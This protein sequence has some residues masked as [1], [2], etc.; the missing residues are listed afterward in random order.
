MAR[1]LLIDDEANIRLMVRLALEQQKHTVEE[2]ADGDEGL[3]KF[4]DGSGWDLILLDQRMPGIDGLS[5]MKLMRLTSP[6]TKIIMITA[7]GTMDLIMDAITAGA[8]NLLR[9]PFTVNILRGVVESALK[10]NYRATDPEEIGAQGISFEF[11]TLNGFRID[12]KQGEG[13]ELGGITLYN[14]VVH[15]PTGETRAITVRIP[16]YINEL[17]KAHT[18]REI[19]PGGPRFLHAFAEEVLANHV[20]QHAELPEDGQIVVT[21]FSPAMVAWVDTLKVSK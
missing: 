14:F 3:T 18:G 7:F 15:S 17:I 4:K 13:L 10:Q 2:A 6:K 8:N 11:T 5:V 12:S 21:E 9:K 16:V 1:I 20:W 19:M